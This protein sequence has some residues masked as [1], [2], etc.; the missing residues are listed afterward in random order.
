MVLSSGKSAAVGSIIQLT[1]DGCVLL[2]FSPFQLKALDCED[3]DG[4]HSGVVSAMI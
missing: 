4:I 2:F 1:G 3:L